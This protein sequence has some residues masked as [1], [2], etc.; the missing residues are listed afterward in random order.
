MKVTPAGLE[1]DL[2]NIKAIVLG[3][4]RAMKDAFDAGFYFAEDGSEGPFMGDLLLLDGKV[5]MV[6]VEPLTEREVRHAGHGAT[7]ATA[8][9]GPR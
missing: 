4:A 1:S 2:K 9:R 8:P 5:K 3:A 7:L 6:D